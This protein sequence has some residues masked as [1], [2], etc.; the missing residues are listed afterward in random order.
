M[1]LIQVKN[2]SPLRLVRKADANRPRRGSANMPRDGSMTPRDLI[3]KLDVRHVNAR[4]AIATA[5][6]GSTTCS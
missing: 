3:A 4:S 1:T 6:T 2:D 5:A